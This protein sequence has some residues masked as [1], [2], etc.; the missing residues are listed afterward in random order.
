MGY[1]NA[2]DVRVLI[3]TELVDEVIENLIV[4]ADADLDRMLGGTT[5]DASFK[6]KA[7]MYL[8]AAMIADG[9][10]PSYTVGNIRIDM[11]KQAAS[12]RAQVKE[13]VEEARAGSAVIKSSVYQKID[14]DI[15]YD[16]E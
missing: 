10:P 4:L 1:C 14:E 11:G 13:S 15:R 8:T 6:K 16:E 9:G 3:E 2:S 7:S 12:W 5:A